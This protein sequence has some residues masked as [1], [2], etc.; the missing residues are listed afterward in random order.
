MYVAFCFPVY[1]SRLWVEMILAR[2]GLGE[3]AADVFLMHNLPYTS[4]EN[5]L[6]DI[7]IT[8]LR[9]RV[10]QET[11]ELHRSGSEVVMITQCIK[12]ERY[13]AIWFYKKP[14]LYYN[15]AHL[16]DRDPVLNT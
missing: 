13:V 15:R 6:P 8:Q 9:Q 2:S 12:E 10:L 14:K 16:A 4:L 7:A 3:A 1:S 11:F 5:R